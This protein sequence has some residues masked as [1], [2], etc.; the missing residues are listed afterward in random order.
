MVTGFILSKGKRTVFND[1]VP[2]KCPECASID[3]EFDRVRISCK[4]CE[5]TE[6]F[7]LTRDLEDSDAFSE[8]NK[9]HAIS[10][11]RRWGFAG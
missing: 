2:A 10:V 1:D 9:Q 7:K 8:L 3:V 4:N 5:T 6:T 11:F